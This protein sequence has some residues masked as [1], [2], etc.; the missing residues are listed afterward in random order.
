MVVIYNTT[1][2]EETKTAERRLLRASPT[3]APEGLNKSMGGELLDPYRRSY[4]Y[5]LLGPASV[6][7]AHRG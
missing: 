5:V 7:Q 4:I 1:S 3:H 6:R 2:G